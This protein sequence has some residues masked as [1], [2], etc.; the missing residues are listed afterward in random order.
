M[1]FTLSHTAASLPFLKRSKAVGWAPA[2]VFGCMAPDLLFP[3]PHYG[4]RVHTHTIK[5]LVALD[6]PLAVLFALFWVYFLSR[7]V[8]RL[9]GLA[10]WGTG[11]PRRFS[12]KMAI[13]GAFVGCATHLFWDM[14][15][16]KGSPLLAHPFFQR[17][18]FSGQGGELTVQTLVWYANSILG[19]VALA[20]W[21]R[22]RLHTRGEGLRRTFLA[23]P[24]LRIY[25]AF[26]LPY[27]L[28]LGAALH[29]RPDSLGQFFLNLVY[30][31]DMVRVGMAVSLLSVVAMVWWET[32]RPARVDVEPA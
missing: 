28:I 8:S 23:G 15:T 14:F 27:G 17:E 19:M 30:L 16:H 6:T 1:P 12:L 10:T 25:A 4:Q 5:G 11:D 26:L 2:L 9:P 22:S 13:A 20:L 3:L 18:I 24:W 21:A 7:R 29:K 31:M 32:R